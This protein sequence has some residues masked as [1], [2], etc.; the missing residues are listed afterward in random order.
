MRQ[1]DGIEQKSSSNLKTYLL[2]SL[3]VLA[4]LGL[5]G[6]GIFVYQKALSGKKIASVTPTPTI[7]PTTPTP[8]ESGEITPTPSLDKSAL[9]IEIL[10]GT[11]TSGA[12]G[13]AAKLLENSGYKGIK[14]GNAAQYDYEETIIGIK[15]S[16]K[17]FLPLISESLAKNYQIAEDSKTL[18]EKDSFD[19]IITLG[20]K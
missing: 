2:I 8:T 16:K 18:D 15:E 1:M 17:D 5:V 7:N 20:K 4:G 3:V 11:G 9:K 12:A 19:V 13:K 14:T 6:G 10:N